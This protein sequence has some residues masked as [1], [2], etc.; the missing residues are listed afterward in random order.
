MTNEIA[1][2]LSDSL[3]PLHDAQLITVL[4]GLSKV[5][6][7]QRNQGTIKFPV[8]YDEDSQQYQ[9]ENSALVPNAKQRAI[10]YF[11]GNDTNITDFNT[12]KSK[13]D[14]RVRLV[15][16]YNMDKFTKMPQGFVDSV[17][18]SKIMECISKAKPRPD[19]IIVGLSVDVTRLLD[20]AN[21]LFSRYTYKEERG[22]YLQ[23]PY[24]ALGMDITVT[25]QI[26]HGCPIELLPVDADGCC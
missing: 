7:Q 24:F 17:F 8:P 14:T 18:T 10:L 15:C 13:A 6:S 2:I 11:E 12:K 25:Y 23:S 21:T 26:N 3:Q 20:S 16:W 19:G 4:G 22:Q 5:A 1:R 9:I